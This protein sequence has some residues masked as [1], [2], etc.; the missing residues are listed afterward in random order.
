MTYKKAQGIGRYICIDSNGDRPFLYVGSLEFA[1]AK[2][3]NQFKQNYQYKEGD[4]VYWRSGIR[5]F[6]ED[7][8]SGEGLVFNDLECRLR[9]DCRPA[10]YTEEQEHLNQSHME[11]AVKMT[12][13]EI[14]R[15]YPLTE[16]D[17]WSTI[18]PREALKN[19]LRT[20]DIDF[21]QYFRV[22]TKSDAEIRDFIREFR[23]KPISIPGKFKHPSEYVQYG[24]WRLPTEPNPNIPG[25]LIFGAAGLDTT[26]SKDFSSMWVGAP[27]S[28]MPEKGKGLYNQLPK[29]KLKMKPLKDQLEEL[30]FENV[31][32]IINLNKLKLEKFLNTLTGS[33]KD[34][35]IEL[36]QIGDDPVISSEGIICWESALK[37]A[38]KKEDVNSRIKVLKADIDLV[39]TLK[40]N[41]EIK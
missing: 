13:D 8:E 23:N 39:K 29:Y 11:C 18:D 19:L 27:N 32:D 16:K 35:E 10:T 5:V 25:I 1:S 37:N 30:G 9:R 7:N 14:I 15:Q 31:D 41:L 38:R 6:K 2:Q 22:Y 34:L 3:I 20:G 12:D 17:M 40:N 4:L 24:K 28:T 26:S 36:A 21:W 33:V